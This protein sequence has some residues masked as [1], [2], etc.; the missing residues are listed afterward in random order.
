MNHKVPLG[1]GTYC[2]CDLMIPFFSF[3]QFHPM[4]FPSLCLCRQWRRYTSRM[5]DTSYREI[6]RQEGQDWMLKK[7]K[8]KAEAGSWPS[9]APFAGGG[10]GNGQ[11]QHGQPQQ[12]LR[13]RF[14]RGCLPAAQGTW[15]S[16]S[17]SGWCGA[18]V[19]GVY[20]HLHR[21]QNMA[22]ARPAGGMRPSPLAA[23]GYRPKMAVW[24]ATPPQ[25]G[26]RAS[27]TSSRGGRGYGRVGHVPARGVGR[28]AFAGQY[29][30]RL[31]GWRALGQTQQGGVGFGSRVGGMGPRLSHGGQIPARARPAMRP[32][33]H[34]AYPSYQW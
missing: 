34:P 30:H 15:S 33:K 7:K 24:G 32:P 2:L 27:V 31:Q 18:G 4:F 25:A 5:Y 21:Y 6:D 20:P 8:S 29:N 22:F 10:H 26:G 16:T 13:Q 17:A 1:Q 9:V 14:S 23:E 12:Q 19:S 3:H 11:R 28:R